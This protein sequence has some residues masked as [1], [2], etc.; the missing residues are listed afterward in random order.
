MACLWCNNRNKLNIRFKLSQ[1]ADPS[2]ETFVKFKD[3]FFCTKCHSILPFWNELE[4]K[5]KLLEF[6]LRNDL[7]KQSLSLVA[8]QYRNRILTI[9]LPRK[10]TIQYRSPYEDLRLDSCIYC[11]R[12]LKY[13]SDTEIDHCIPWKLVPINTFWNLY[14]SCNICNAV[15][16]TNLPLLTPFSLQQMEKYFL[17]LVN[18]KNKRIKSLIQKDLAILNKKMTLNPRYK[19]ISS[20]SPEIKFEFVLSIQKQLKT[21]IQRNR[22]SKYLYQMWKPPKYKP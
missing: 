15:K 16:G 11:G 19:Q 6:N 17:I 8:L 22:G 10:R 3:K 18:T 12:L 5:R 9:K 1:L 7:D 2:V 20:P 21:L 4:I 14:P 13:T